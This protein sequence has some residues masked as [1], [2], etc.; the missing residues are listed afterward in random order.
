LV[1][2]PL[3]SSVAAVSVG[4][5]GSTAMLDLCYTEDSTAEVDLNVVVTG[6][7]GLVEI[8]GTAEGEPFDRAMLDSLLDLGIAGCAELSKLQREALGE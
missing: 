2:E 7:G 3:K 5:V 6:D 1:G 8:Q 4:V